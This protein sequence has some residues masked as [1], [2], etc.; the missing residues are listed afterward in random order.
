MCLDRI[1][2]KLLTA[3]SVFF[4]AVCKSM[5]AWGLQVSGQSKQHGLHDLEKVT[6]T[7]VTSPWHLI[8]LTCDLVQCNA[9][10]LQRKG[11]ASSSSARSKHEALAFNDFGIILQGR[12]IATLASEEMIAPADAPHQVCESRRKQCFSLFCAVMDIN[13]AYEGLKHCLLTK[14]SMLHTFGSSCSSKVHTKEAAIWPAD[15]VKEKTDQDLRTSD[16][17]RSCIS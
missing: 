7:L 6:G 12:E 11:P 17:A 14:E 15:G 8:C 13:S 9:C 4:L 1:C 10:G 2:V 3:I 16:Y 5:E